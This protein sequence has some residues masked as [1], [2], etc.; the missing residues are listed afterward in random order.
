LNII[1]IKI[2]WYSVFWVLAYG[3][4]IILLMDISL[5]YYSSELS[6]QITDCPKRTSFRKLRASGCL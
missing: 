6:N 3:K 1:L 4:I 5:D 2:E